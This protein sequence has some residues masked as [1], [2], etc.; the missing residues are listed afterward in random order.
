LYTQVFAAK[1][2]FDRYRVLVNPDEEVPYPAYPK[3]HDFAFNTLNLNLVLRWEYNP[4][5]TLFLVWS[6]GRF[7]DYQNTFLYPESELSPYRRT[8]QDR[9]FDTF[10]LESTNIFMLKF[11]YLLQP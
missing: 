11:S 8:T 4:G 5:S 6:Q 1:G 3:S 9:F 2:Q 10:N 7:G